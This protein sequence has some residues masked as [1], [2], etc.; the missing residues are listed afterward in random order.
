MSKL[1]RF[2][3][4]LEEG[5]L[6]RFDN[7]IHRRKYTNRSEA[8]RDMIRHELLKE[9]WEEGG[10]VA[11]AITFIYDHHTREL[12]SKITDIQHDSQEVII[13]TQHIHLDHH[14]CLEIVAV[15]GRVKKVLKLADSLKAIKGV[16]HC[17]LSMTGS[18]EEAIN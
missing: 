6:Q 9:E 8:L 18:G 12:L 13:S 7:L 14:H 1:V 11:G 4:S 17:T 15:R 2:G 16:R 5:L 3:V 10:E